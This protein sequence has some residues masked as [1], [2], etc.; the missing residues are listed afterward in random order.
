[1]WNH[2][3]QSSGE[4]LV[5]GAACAQA[6]PHERNDEE[7]CKM[8]G[9]DWHLRGVRNLKQLICTAGARALLPSRTAGLAAS[10]SSKD[11]IGVFRNGRYL[12]T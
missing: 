1:L 9:A 7:D 11:K 12:N 4:L 5:D 6:A 2:I 3:A 10:Y 8:A